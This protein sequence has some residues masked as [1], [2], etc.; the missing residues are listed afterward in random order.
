MTSVSGATS[1]FTWHTHTYAQPQKHI[2]LFSFFQG[3]LRQCRMC[4]MSIDW[5]ERDY[6]AWRQ[7]PQ[8]NDPINWANQRGKRK[9][10]CAPHSHCRDQRAHRLLRDSSHKDSPEDIKMPLSGS[11]TSSTKSI[12]RAPSELERS[13]SI[14]V[15]LRSEFSEFGLSVASCSCARTVWQVNII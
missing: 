7:N 15:S 14:T 8:T 2:Y 11:S 3:G 10:L 12:R 6:R 5:W 4:L 1:P 9:A 13:D